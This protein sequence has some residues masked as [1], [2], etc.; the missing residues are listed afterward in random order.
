LQIAEGK[1]V[2]FCDRSNRGI[3]KQV[4]GILCGTPL[5]AKLT[6]S[7]FPQFSKPLPLRP[8]LT[9]PM[10]LHRWEERVHIIHES[11]RL[12]ERCRSLGV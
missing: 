5:A 1:V 3:T 4:Q 2:P 9:M 7:L 10:L 11:V 12:S 6:L 8:D